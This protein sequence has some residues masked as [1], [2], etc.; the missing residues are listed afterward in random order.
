MS[1]IALRPVSSIAVNVARICS[2][3]CRRNTAT[4]ACTVI[5]LSACATT[6]C[7]SRAMRS[8]SSAILE[9]DLGLDLAGVRGGR[10][11]PVQ[12]FLPDEVADQGRHDADGDP[13]ERQDRDRVVHVGQDHQRRPEDDRGSQRGKAAGAGGRDGVEHEHH[14][15]RPVRVVGRRRGAQR[16]GRTGEQQADG[17]RVAAAG[18][19]DHR[20]GED[21]QRQ[22]RVLIGRA[23]HLPRPER[24]HEQQRRHGVQHQ[25]VPGAHPRGVREGVRRDVGHEPT[26]SLRMRG[27]QRS[28]A[29]TIPG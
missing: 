22:P 5:R 12:P 7:S 28:R 24:Q 15:E 17:H 18:Q 6:S 11:R 16:D 23:A 26:V 3:S 29:E 9:A 8:R 19:E 25:P 2:A 10:L 1:P 27:D 20:G 14:R 21:Q 4:P 13:A